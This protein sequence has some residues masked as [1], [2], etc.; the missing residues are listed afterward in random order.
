M[1][2]ALCIGNLAGNGLTTFAFH[3]GR[4]LIAAGHSVAVIAPSG[5]EWAPRLAAEGLQIVLC[6]P[7]TWESKV[8]FS[9]RF[10]NHIAQ[11]NYKI[12]FVVKEWWMEQTLLG[13]HHIPATTA[14]VAVLANDEA[15]SFELARRAGMVWNAV[16]TISPRIHQKAVALLPDLGMEF[17][18]CGIVLPTDAAVCQRRSWELPLRLLYVGRLDQLKGILLLP[19]IMAI[20]RR[21]DLPVQLTVIGDGPDRELLTDAITEQHVAD[22]ID[23]RGPQLSDAVYAAM[24]THHVL[25]MP[26]CSEGGLS[27]VLIEAQA[28]G[29]V[30]IASRLAGSTDVA[31]EDGVSGHLVAV[32]APVV[33]AQ[34]VA[35]L[36]DAG[37]WQAMSRA[38]IERARHH[39]SSAAMGAHYLAL[40]E[41]I[42]AGNY[43]LTTSRSARLRDVYVSLPFRDYLPAQLR[44]QLYRMRS[45]I[46]SIAGMQTGQPSSLHPQRRG[47]RVRYLLRHMG[48]GEARRLL[49]RDL[50]CR[51]HRTRGRH[52]IALQTDPALSDLMRWLRPG[53]LLLDAA[54]DELF[55]LELLL[56]QLSAN[57]TPAIAYCCDSRLTA[58]RGYHPVET[59]WLLEQRGY[60]IW[61]LT[62]DGPIKRP[63]GWYTLQPAGTPGRW[64]LAAP[65]GWC[66]PEVAS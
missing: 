44:R 31:V 5:G 17:I 46:L 32:G 39:F 53:D 1:K 2:I 18:P 13:L 54:G 23:L 29:C 4:E 42:A 65:P 41:R 36:L 58:R 26:T 22:L 10:A 33:F 8:H 35:R 14:L 55:W 64:L 66:A 49:W 15:A 48:H 57:Q 19:E 38:G 62:K 52:D 63:D 25:L 3:L 59:V 50:T 34:A 12:V 43:P 51:L 27:F 21:W 24:Q 30:P 11:S 16:V 6:Q 20:C 45:H 61:L 40:I 60:Q 7:G 9:M 37:R 56:R 47:R 28:N